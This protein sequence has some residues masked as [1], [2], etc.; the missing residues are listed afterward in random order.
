MIYN[1]K[2]ILNQNE[3]TNLGQFPGSPGREQHH[4][5]P[6]RFASW[7]SADKP[8]GAPPGFSQ[9]PS[10]CPQD[11]SGSC[12]WW[13][14]YAVQAAG[15]QSNVCQPEHN[16]E[17]FIHVMLYMHTATILGTTHTHTHTHNENIPFRHISH[18][19]QHELLGKTTK[20]VRNFYDILKF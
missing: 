3:P 4:G 8:A 19:P 1:L 2:S 14:A 6:G 9:L 16:E 7:T 18:S 17:Q 20:K 11:S 12:P 13:I 15:S 5:T 10:P